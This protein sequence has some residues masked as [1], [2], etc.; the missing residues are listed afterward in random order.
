MSDCPHCLSKLTNNELE[1]KAALAFAKGYFIIVK[2]VFVAL[3][4][5][6]LCTLLCCSIKREKT[7]LCFTFM[8]ITKT[9]IEISM[10]V[11]IYHSKA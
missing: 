7:V 10:F 5:H 2:K 8:L 1:E 3:N 11:I 4:T 6:H 9:K